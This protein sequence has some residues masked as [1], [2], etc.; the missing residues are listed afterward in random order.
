MSRRANLKKQDATDHDLLI[1][2]FADGILK[3]N[4]DESDDDV[5]R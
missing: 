5:E 3:Q 1:G 4:G 2:D